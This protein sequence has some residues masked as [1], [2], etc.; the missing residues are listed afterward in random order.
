MF[1]RS[2]FGSFGSYLPADSRGYVPQ[3]GD[4]QKSF[5]FQGRMT[6]AEW[7]DF[8]AEAIVA[9][10]HAEQALTAWRLVSK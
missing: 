4:Q 1:H 6:R 5:S 9:T 8:V 7:A 2:N 3:A 10:Q